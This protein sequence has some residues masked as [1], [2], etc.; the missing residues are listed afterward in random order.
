MECYSS[1]KKNEIMEFVGKWMKQENIILNEVIQTHNK[2][3]GAMDKVS[4][5]G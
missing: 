5:G 3:K 4:G 2:S 1:L